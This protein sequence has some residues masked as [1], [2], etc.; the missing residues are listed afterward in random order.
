MLKWFSLRRVLLLLFIGIV[1]A[2]AFMYM[3]G[4]H[5]ALDIIYAEFVIVMVLSIIEAFNNRGRR[6]A[7]TRKTMPRLR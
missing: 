6:P 5:I 1:L 4:V 2:T 3:R 7:P